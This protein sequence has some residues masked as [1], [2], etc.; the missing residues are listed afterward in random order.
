M[1][2][3]QLA[4][5]SDE[6]SLSITRHKTRSKSPSAAARLT[7][8]GALAATPWVPPP[9]KTTKSMKYAWQVLLFIVTRV[10]FVVLRLR[11]DYNYA[12]FQITKV[13]TERQEQTKSNKKIMYMTCLFSTG[14][15]IRYIHNLKI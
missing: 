15:K 13:Q 7:N 9:A 11:I 1:L 6:P 3:Q 8:S 12:F 2:T 14:H 5:N 10:L 4:I